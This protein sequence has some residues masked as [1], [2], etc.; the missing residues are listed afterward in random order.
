MS[1]SSAAWSLHPQLAKDTINIGDLPLCRV[2]VIQDANYPWLLLV[3]RRTG[4]AEI[5]DL[6]E[7]EQAQLMTEIARVGRALKA[8]TECD[9]LN[10]AALGNVVPQLH[11]HLIARRTTDAAWPRPVWGVVPPLAHD[12]KE[13]EAFIRALRKRIWLASD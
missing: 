8:V 9:K 2:L 13:V 7:V 3:P 12:P 11:V 4:V 1:D 10:V 6:D 5:I